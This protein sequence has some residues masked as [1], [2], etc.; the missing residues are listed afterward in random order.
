M[1]LGGDGAPPTCS[2]GET[3]THIHVIPPH[4]YTPTKA[5][6]HE[7][8]PQARPQQLSSW[9]GHPHACVSVCQCVRVR[10][11]A[12]VVLPIKCL[13]Q[14]Q[15]CLGGSRKKRR[16]RSPLVPCLRQEGDNS[17]YAMSQATVALSRAH[18][19]S[20]EELGKKPCQGWGAGLCGRRH[21]PGARSPRSLSLSVC[22]GLGRPASCWAS[23]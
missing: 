14:V 2:P 16:A 20:P 15:A 21:P 7:D 17:D 9:W 22:L 13:C 18:P 10:S 5:C 4:T 23:S 12:D 19:G 8:T 1:R 11:W 3:C 6:T